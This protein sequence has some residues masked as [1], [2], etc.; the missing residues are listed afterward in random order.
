MKGAFHRQC[1]PNAGSV[2]VQNDTEVQFC[3]SLGS[4][5]SCPAGYTCLADGSV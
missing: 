5:S 3:G 2:F 1:F 4:Q